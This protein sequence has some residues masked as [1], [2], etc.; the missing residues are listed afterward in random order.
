MLVGGL[1]AGAVLALPNLTLTGRPASRS[2]ASGSAATDSSAA[3]YVFVYGVPEST[4]P[5]GSLAAAMTPAAKTANL[6]APKAVAA[7][8]AAAPVSSP[9]ASSVALVTVDNVASGAK[10]TLTVVNS[11]TAVIEKQGSLTVPGVAD[12]LSIIASPVFVPGTATI[13]LVL[14]IS[15]ATD[16]R[17]AV[18]LDRHT[19]EKTPFQAVTWRS[20]HGL[21]YFDTS[22]GR[23]G[24]LFTINEAP[25]LA[26]HSVAASS[27]DLFLWTTEEL[28]PGLAKGTPMPVPTLSLIPVGSG[29]ARIRKTSALPWPASEPV[30]AL[31]SGD[32]A[33][34]VNGRTIQVASAKT[35]ETSQTTI[36][37]LSRQPAKPSAV[38]M[39]ARPDGTVFLT[40]PGI[41]RAVVVDPLNSFAV[42]AQVDF[43][44]PPYP[45]AAPWSKAVLSAAGDTLFT[46]GG[47]T[48]AG[49]SAYDV[50]T[51][52]LTGYYSNSEHYTGLYL[53]PNGHLLGT[54]PTNP[55]LTFF[56]PELDVLGSATTN[57]Q[58]AAVF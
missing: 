12:D 5:G 47:K 19:G 53:L 50:S 27:S 41:G 8:L 18:K 43:A 26:L 46:L 29:T 14:G 55:R 2:A 34:F 40:K 54:S 6:P 13:A 11:A 3:R 31:A 44:V 56:S 37:A 16:R 10:V 4:G 24:E 22:S 32:V 51:G 28:Q 1:G 15:E 7:Q 35:G 57:V 38:T 48:A 25:Q 58:V 17:M 23:F 9:D 33:R 42:K 49:V 20:H 30:V 36:E 21:A 39:T 52:K 45:G